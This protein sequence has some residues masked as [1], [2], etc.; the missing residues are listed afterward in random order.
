MVGMV[1]WA[2]VALPARAEEAAAR[3]AY[4]KGMSAMQIGEWK[5]AQKLFK[6]A[7][8]EKKDYAEAYNKEGLALFNQEKYLEAVTYFKQA[9]FLNPRITEAWYNLGFGYERIK[10]DS[11]AVDRYR[12]AEGVTPAS[13]PTTLVQVH[14]RLGMLLRKLAVQKD[15]EKADIHPAIKEMEM[16][17]KMDGDFAEAHHELGRMYD[18]VA[19]YPEAIHQYDQAIRYHR[20][21]VEAYTDRGIAYW[22]DGD[23]DAALADCRKAVDINPGFAGAHYNLAEVLLARVEVLKSQDKTAVYHEEAEKAIDEYRLA[24]GLDP[25]TLDYHFGLAKAYYNFH[26][27]DNARKV[28]G[29]IVKMKGQKWNKQAHDFLALIKKEQASFIS[30]YPKPTPTPEQ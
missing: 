3:A 15:K 30:H 5:S 29:K 7:I 19:R 20:D 18:M 13:D 6:R 1:L 4:T 14:Y 8:E 22:H 12:R 16:A 25:A 2:W 11:E 26:D 24:A 17:V 9:V 27:Y 21:Y 10:K 28:L 23:W